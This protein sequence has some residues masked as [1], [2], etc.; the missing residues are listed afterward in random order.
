M[1]KAKLKEAIKE[2]IRIAETALP[3]WIYD[4][5][6]EAYENSEGRAK[7]QLGA[8][9]RNIELAVKERKPMCQDT[10][11][12]V[13]SIKLGRDFPISY[14][15]LI[16]I[17]EESL[18][19]ATSEIPIRPNT[20]DPLTGFN[21]GD[22][23]GKG[24]PIVEIEEINEGD[25]LEISIRPKG[26]GS[27]Y[28]SKLCMIPPSMG[29]KGVKECLF[30]AILDA[31]GK[32]C[33]PGI[34]SVAFGGTVEEAVKLSKSNL[35]RKG[36]HLEERI[37][38]LEEKWKQEINALNIGPMGLG[39]TPTILDLKIDYNYRHPASYPVAVTFNCWA[40]RESRIRIKRDGSWE[41]ISENVTSKDL[42]HIEDINVQARELKLPVDSNEVRK[43]K[44][45]DVVYVTGTIVTARDEAHKKIIEEGKPPIDLKG[46]A[47]YHCGPVVKKEGTEW[48]VI[49]AGP[50]T[51]ARMNELEAKVLEITGAKLV[52]GKG[53][54]K[55]D[56]LDTF[57]RYGAAY[58]AFP[59][60]A[61]LLAAKAIKRVKGVYWLEELGIPEAMWVFE[62]ERFGP[63]I[64]AMDSHGNS[65]YEE[66]NK[67][68]V[69]NA[70]RYL[71]EI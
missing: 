50:T 67:A 60:G 29:L 54:M 14:R 62:V 25:A 45:G 61:A 63:L 9:L 68:A 19:E 2:G 26:G 65:L 35:Y 30:K 11:L 41:V 44:A 36:K 23:T 38:K 40:A 27:E 43:L 28:P 34:V 55:R 58:L 47:I 6:V 71:K 10:G 21:P 15:D 33:P 8:I 1:I 51:S 20:M 37:S 5:L 48:K 16:G 49:A 13:F 59:G 56:L 17:I 53:G 57:S 3:K 39:G 70:K 69:E 18:R 42:L 64:V 46:L 32:P 4:Y 24:M 66:V 12:L 31:G 22:N 7:A 52:I